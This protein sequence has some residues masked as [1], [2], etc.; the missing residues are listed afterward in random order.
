MANGNVTG[1]LKV[2]QLYTRGVEVCMRY[3]EHFEIYEHRSAQCE[4]DA[5]NLNSQDY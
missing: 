4:K 2:C 1:M 3:T 5:D